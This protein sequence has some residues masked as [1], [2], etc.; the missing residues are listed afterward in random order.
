MV[1]KSEGDGVGWRSE[2]ELERVQGL[3]ID[4]VLEAPV[5]GEVEGFLIFVDVHLDV[6]VGRGSGFE[7]ALALERPEL[8][9]IL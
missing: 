7:F 2:V 9:D 1:R 4:G 6:V 5:S 3:L 8:V